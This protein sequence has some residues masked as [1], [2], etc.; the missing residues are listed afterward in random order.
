MSVKGIPPNDILYSSNTRVKFLDFF[1]PNIPPIDAFV[2]KYC[3]YDLKKR[4]EGVVHGSV[5]FTKW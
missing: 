3:L 1:L 5:T 2:Y 4:I